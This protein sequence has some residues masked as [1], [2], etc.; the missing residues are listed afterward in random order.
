MKKIVKVYWKTIEVE[1]NYEAEPLCDDIDVWRDSDHVLYFHKECCV[2]FYE[3]RYQ[4]G[5]IPMTYFFSEVYEDC[6]VQD[7]G[8]RT[9]LDGD[10]KKIRALIDASL[11]NLITA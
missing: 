2:A 7:H 8:L 9:M 3:L 5:V 1:V 6:Y 11:A 4:E 10:V